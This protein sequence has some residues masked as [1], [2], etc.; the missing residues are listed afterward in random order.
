[1]IF[2]MLLGITL[3]LSY[4]ARYPLM[5]KVCISISAIFAVGQGLW[6]LSEQWLGLAPLGPDWLE[7]A[8][9]MVCYGAGLILAN[10]FIRLIPRRRIRFN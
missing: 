1:M 6:Q 7:Q 2:A 8:A 9:Y 10:T 3:L 5:L 4:H